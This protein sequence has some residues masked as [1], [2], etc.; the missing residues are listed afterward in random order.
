MNLS[1]KTVLVAG[2][3]VDIPFFS[4]EYPAIDRN[5]FVDALVPCAA[6]TPGYFGN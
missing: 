3:G 6:H 1:H 2:A 4:G 5:E